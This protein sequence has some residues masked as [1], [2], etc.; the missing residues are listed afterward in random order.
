MVVDVATFSDKMGIDSK[1]KSKSKSNGY[2]YGFFLPHFCILRFPFLSSTWFF[3]PFSPLDLIFSTLPSK[4][5]FLTFS[6]H[7]AKFSLFFLLDPSRFQSSLSGLHSGLKLFDPISMWFTSIS[8]SGICF[9]PTHFVNSWFSSSPYVIW[10][11]SR[12]KLQGVDLIRGNWCW[13]F[14]W[15]NFRGFDFLPTHRQW[16]SSLILIKVLTGGI[17]MSCFWI[18]NSLLFFHLKLQVIELALFFVVVL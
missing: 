10:F 1:S 7:L 17:S 12:K 14:F 15:G 2:G 13:S 4:S 3:I 11:D 8:I 5:H 6:P 18:L 9:V 16:I